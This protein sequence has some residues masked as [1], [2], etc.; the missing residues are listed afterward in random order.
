MWRFCD[1][2]TISV[3]GVSLSCRGGCLFWGGGCHF[4]VGEDLYF[5]G[6]GVRGGCLFFKGGCHFLAGGVAFLYTFMAWGRDVLC[7]IAFGL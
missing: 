2:S 4:L 5:G 6:G 3:L 7:F 1:D